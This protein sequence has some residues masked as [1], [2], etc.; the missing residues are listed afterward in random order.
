MQNTMQLELIS[1]CELNTNHS[2]NVFRTLN[3]HIYFCV[4]SVSLKE[5]GFTVETV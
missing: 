3:L 1:E 4:L 2:S 5:T